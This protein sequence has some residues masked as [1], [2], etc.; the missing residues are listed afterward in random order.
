MDLLGPVPIVVH[1]LDV[2]ILLASGNRTGDSFLRAW[3]ESPIDKRPCD[4]AAFL[5]AGGC[6]CN[7]GNLLIRLNRMNT[8]ILCNLA[9][10]WYPLS[11]RVRTVIGLVHRPY[12]QIFYLRR[13]H[14]GHWIAQEQLVIDIYPFQ[15]AASLIL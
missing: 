2:Q 13:H 8:D 7:L 11:H 4:R 10:A 6:H 9:P 12:F 15:S 3:V 1:R 5:Q 14:I